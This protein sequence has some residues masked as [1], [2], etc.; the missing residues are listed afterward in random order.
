MASPCVA[1]WWFFKVLDDFCDSHGRH[2]GASFVECS[3]PGQFTGELNLLLGL[4][5]NCPGGLLQV[6]SRFH[7]FVVFFFVVGLTRYCLVTSCDIHPW[8][9]VHEWGHIK[10]KRTLII[11]YVQGETSRKSVHISTIIQLR[12]APSGSL[13]SPARIAL[14]PDTQTSPNLNLQSGVLSFFCALLWCKRSP[15]TIIYCNWCDIHARMENMKLWN[16][17]NAW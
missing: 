14:W 1:S 11:Y 9:Y 6:S 7:K 13:E 8:I 10:R 16:Q 5:T 12:S 2:S 3:V 17:L 4:V 15:Y